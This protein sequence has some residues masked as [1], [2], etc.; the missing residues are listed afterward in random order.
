MVAS[1]FLN[2]EGEDDEV[3]NPDW[4]MSANIELTELNQLERDFLQAMVS[5][6][7]WLLFLRAES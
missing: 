5:S 6:T 1:K 3:F 4:A 2:D 7:P